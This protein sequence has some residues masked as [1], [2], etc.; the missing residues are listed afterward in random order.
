MFS[1]VK[2]NQISPIMIQFS[3]WKLAAG[4]LNVQNNLTNQQPGSRKM[5]KCHKGQPWTAFFVLSSRGCPPFLP[6]FAKAS[7]SWTSSVQQ[8]LYCEVITDKATCKKLETGKMI[9]IYGKS[10]KIYELPGKDKAEML[11]R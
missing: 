10:W 2:R 5:G 11:A 9:N 1:L 4:S 3:Y 8:N 7:A 6:F